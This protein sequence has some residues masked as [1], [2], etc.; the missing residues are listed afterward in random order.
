[1]S[2]RVHRHKLVCV[3]LSEVEVG[4][5]GGL[6]VQGACVNMIGCLV[7]AQPS[8]TVICGG[9]GPNYGVTQ[10]QCAAL[11]TADRTL[12]MG[13]AGAKRTWENARRAA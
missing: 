10:V 4:G 13:H 3:C 1:M 9:G 12:L 6:G 11:S 8:R 5:G 2:S 7:R